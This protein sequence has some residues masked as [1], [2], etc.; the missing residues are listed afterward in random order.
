MPAGLIEH[1][2]DALVGT[3]ADLPGEGGQDRAEQSGVDAIDKE[4]DH[5]PGSWPNKAVEIQP[6]V[7]VMARGDRAAAARC[8]DLAPDR[9]QAEPMFVKR[10]DFNRDRRRCTLEFGNPGLKFF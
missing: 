1:E 5:R 2:E 7:S 4:P 3:G 8:P 6:L 9:L 10:P